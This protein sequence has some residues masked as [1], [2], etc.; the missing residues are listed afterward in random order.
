MANSWQCKWM[1]NHSMR[2]RKTLKWKC[3]NS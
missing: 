3:R 2:S 1:R